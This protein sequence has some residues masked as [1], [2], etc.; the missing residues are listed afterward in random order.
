M[1]RIVKAAGDGLTVTGGQLA[2]NAIVR[3]VPDVI[4]ASVPM[5]GTLNPVLKDIV[6]VVA[7]SY[8]AP[9]FLGERRAEFFIAGQASAAI[10]RGIRAANVPVISTMLGEYDPIRLGTYARG[11]RRTL[12]GGATYAT[13]GTLAGNVRALRNVGVYTEGVPFA[14]SL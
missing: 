4:P 6:G 5:A 2:Q 12:P 9:R 14:G 11:G 13:G 7:G 1:G 3:Y 8:F 10:N